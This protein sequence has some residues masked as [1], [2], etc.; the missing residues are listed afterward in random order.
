MS[1]AGPEDRSPHRPEL[2]GIRALAFLAVFWNHARPATHN[3]GAMGVQVFFALS[4]FLITRILVQAETGALGP[5]LGRFYVRRTL[6]IF[7][8]YY[9]LLVVVGLGRGWVDPGWHLTYTYNIRVY[10]GHA[11]DDVLAHFWTLCVEEQFYLIYP[12]LLWL[13]PGRLR[14]GLIVAL[15]AASKGFQVYAHGSLVMPW[16]RLLLPYCGEYLLWGCLAGLVDL[17]L[18][19]GTAGGRSCFVLGLPL[20]VLGWRFHEHRL[21]A[22]P[23][24]LQ[25]ALGVSTLGIGSALVVVGAW[26]TGDRWIVAPLACP[27]LAWLGRI[28]YGLYAFHMPV[29]HLRWLDQVPY[30]FLIPRP[31]GDLALTIALAALSWRYFEGP[32]NRQKGRLAPAP[33]A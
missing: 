13:T 18:G 1:G 7:P 5:D 31:Y 24:H 3:W 30:A 8:L 33:R 21:P 9:A 17:R 25:D 26:R 28:S 29:I 14:L 15:L 27:P 32:I 4:G 11:F 23:A 10:L 12:L 2:D 6:R 16:P 19:P 20:I 22:L